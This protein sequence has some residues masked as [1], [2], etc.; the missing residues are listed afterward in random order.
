MDSEFVPSDYE[1]KEGDRVAALGRWIIDC[2]HD[3]YSAEIHPPLLYV[4]AHSNGTESTHVSIISRP[5]LVSQEFGDGGLYDHLV[6]QL[7]L[8]YPP[9]IYVPADTTGGGQTKIIQ[10]PI[11]G[12]KIF[13]V[14]LRPPGPR[15]SPSERLFVSY[16]IAVRSGVAVQLYNIN[17]DSV[18]MTIVLNEAAYNLAPLPTAQNRN[19]SKCQEKTV[20]PARE[21]RYFSGIQPLS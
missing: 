6:N 12:I 14:V 21:Q 8:V 13:N 5:F 9:G 17:D 2:G 4:V 18:G 11:S 3:G 1:A 15:P 7:L 10:K 20:L 19:V 16:Q